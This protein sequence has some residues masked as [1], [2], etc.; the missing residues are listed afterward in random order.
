[1]IMATNFRQNRHKCW[2]KIIRKILTK[3]DIFPPTAP[4]KNGSP[5]KEL[6]S[7]ACYKVLQGFLKGAAAYKFAQDRVIGYQLFIQRRYMA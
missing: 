6:P 2:L 5:I 7:N 4:I 1:M 3:K